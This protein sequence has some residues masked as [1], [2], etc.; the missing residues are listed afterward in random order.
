VRTVLR[1]VLVCGAVLGCA[2][3][4]PSPGPGPVDRV[5]D[6]AFALEVRTARDHYGTAE[7]IPIDTTIMYLGPRDQIVASSEFGT[8]L[9][10]F[11]LEQLDGPLDM[12]G[13]SSDL[14][15]DTLALTARQ[16][17]AVGFGKS[18]GYSTTDPTAPFWHAYFADKQLH[19]PAGTWRVTA[20]LRAW[21]TPDCSG[22]LDSLDAAVTFRVE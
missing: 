19:L 20:S 21:T 17:L 7:A 12:P 8:T 9:V 11:G 5:Q 16:P 14:M 10:T 13:G 22:R 15:C 2:S 18:G 4:E 1:L 3:P 6:A